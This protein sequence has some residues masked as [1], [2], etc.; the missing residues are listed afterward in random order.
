MT[1]V[2]G[3]QAYNLLEREGQDTISGGQTLPHDQNVVFWY[4][5]VITNNNEYRGLYNYLRGVN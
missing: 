3:W 5:Q 4:S 1:D 2:D